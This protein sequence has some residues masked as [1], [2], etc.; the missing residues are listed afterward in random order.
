MENIT[1]N[2]LKQIEESLEANLRDILDGNQDVGGP[3]V[4]ADILN[5][6]GSSVEKSVLE[7]MDSADPEI[8]EEVR[9]MMF[10][11]GDLVKLTDK[12]LQGQIV[13]TR[14]DA[15]ET[16]VRRTMVENPMGP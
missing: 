4:V 10:V 16:M 8:A 7:Q 12:E 11:F 14:G 5:L 15:S 3:K 1:P 9:N 2:V 6:T 13:I